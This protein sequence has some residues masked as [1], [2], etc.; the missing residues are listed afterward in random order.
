MADEGVQ[1][2]L[3]TILA[4]DVAGYSR[5]V[6]ADEEATLRTL[7]SHRTVVDDLITRHHGRIFGS[8][9]DSVIAEFGSTVEAVR[10]AMAVQEKLSEQNADLPADR[11]MHFRIGINV[12]DVM[13]DGR[14]LM[15]D[16]VNIAA[17]LEGLAE[18]GGITISGST[19]DQVKNKLSVGFED[20]GL[21]KVKNIPE[22]VQTFRL[23]SA[24]ASITASPRKDRKWRV[25]AIATALVLLVAAGALTVWQPWGSDLR[26]A[27]VS[28]MKLSLPDKPSIVVLPFDNLSGDEDQDYF[29]DGITEDIITDISKVSGI[30]VVAGSSSFAFK[31]KDIEIRDVAEEFGVRYV[32]QGSVRRVGDDLRI[33]AQ[34]IDAIRGNNIW[35]DRY[36]RDVSDIFAVQSEV[37]EQVVRAMAVTLKANEHDRLLQKYATNIDAYDAF[38]RARRLVA[39]PGRQNLD[40]GERMFKRAIELDPQFAGGYA[41]L[42]FNYSVKARLRFGD[43]PEEDARRS[44]EFAQKAV[45]VD[46]E[47]AWSYI[48]LAGAHLSNGNHD[49]AVEAARRG[50]QIQPNGYEENL[51]MGFHLYFAGEAAAAVEHLERARRISPIDTI[52]GVAFLANALFMNADYARS[53]ELRL[54]RIEKFATQNPNAYVWLAATQYQL[55]KLDEAAATVEKLR[56]LWPDF[57]LSKWGLV[58][59]FKLAENRERLYNSA[60]GAGVP[61]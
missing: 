45:Q 16:A 4:A 51:F 38:L 43:S 47:F 2:R 21:Q 28:N 46:P 32:L 13:V 40:E 18:P 22:S 54:L 33:T 39:S 9:G 49:A 12:G 59:A 36:D 57:R 11:Q 48:A 52:R 10:C 34:L 27:S 35:G 37:T 60:A 25:P 14:N 44:L 42:A 7:K 5:L 61:E 56:N 53:E 55:G 15:G 23:V 30:F 41:G 3:T 58:K 24:Q 6:A 8:A 31:D 29:A 17:R 1:R 50:V 26:P 19:F 20:I